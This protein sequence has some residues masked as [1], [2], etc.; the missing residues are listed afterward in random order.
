MSRRPDFF[1]VGAPKCGTTALFSYLAAHPAIFMPDRK[2]PNYFCTD[3]HTSGH[4]ATLTEYEA[5]FSSAQPRALTGEA[6]VQ[7]LY[8]KVAIGR[9]MAHNANAKIIVML[10][11]PIESA[12]SMHA[13]WWGNMLE[14]VGDFEQAWR[15]QK[16]RLEGRSLPPRGPHPQLLQYGALYCYAP[17]VRRLLAQAPRTQCLF[18]LF[19]EFF[20]EPSRQFARVLEFLGL[21]PAPAATAFPVVNQT[22]GVRSAR[23]DRLVRHPPAVLVALRRAAHAVAFH[24]LRALQRFNRVVGQ[25]PPL[26]AAFRAEL[27]EYFSVDLPELEQLLGRRLWPSLQSA[28]PPDS[29]QPNP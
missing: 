9:V 8:S 19:E 4:V 12:R 17:Q 13:Y 2:E 18:L 28:V 3:L 22:I 7:Y 23:L 24:P 26:R 29:T 25:K 6:S 10:R 21:P 5:L 15:L 16:P 14:D 11:N 1:I 27:E 20:A